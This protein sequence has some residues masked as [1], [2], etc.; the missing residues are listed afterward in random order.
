MSTATTRL[1]RL[2][3]GLLVSG[4][5][6]VWFVW[7]A[8]WQEVTV[9]LAGV[10][11]GWVVAS[12]TVLFTEFLLRTL[13]WKVLLRRL[14]P[15]A[16]YGRLLTATIIGM[17]LNVCLPFRAGDIAR[18]FLGHRATGLPPLPLVTVAVIERVF[19]LVGLLFVFLGMLVLL[20]ETESGE[21]VTRLEIY[22][23]LVGAAGVVGLGTFLWMAAHEAT[24]RGLYERLVGL[25][26][27]PLRHK[28]LGLF[29]GFAAGLESVRDRRVLVEAALISLLHWT[30][31]AVSIALL[32]RA[33]AIDLPFAAAAFTTVAIALAAALPQAP[34]FFGVFHS[35]T[36][37]T[38][39]LWGLDPGPS[40]AYAIVFWGVSFIPVSIAAILL[41]WRAGLSLRSFWATTPGSLAREEQIPVR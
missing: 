23:S 21:L 38:L 26:P 36:A 18:P 22:G 19:D 4:S 13:R 27:A 9:S 8:H 7:T 24:A 30:N 40:E 14:S 32:F 35:A 37:M 10:H 3:P 41:S 29:D 39:G 1:K 17:G 28:F 25:F 11:W 16:D 2:L 31:G 33:F 5:F 34:G 12:A 6:T 15:Q 20:P